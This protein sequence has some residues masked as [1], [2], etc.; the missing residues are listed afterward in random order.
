M[1]GKFKDFV[2]SGRN[3]PVRMNA[4]AGGRFLTLEDC[5]F[6][7]VRVEYT[8][9]G[10]SGLT[11]YEYQSDMLFA[12]LHR[13]NPEAL[14]IKNVLLH[15]RYL[16]QWIHA[17]ASK[18][19][20]YEDRVDAL[21]RISHKFDAFNRAAVVDVGF[22]ELGLS[23]GQVEYG[24]QFL[25]AV[26]RRSFYFDLR[27]VESWPFGRV[28]N[29]CWMLQDLVTLGCDYPSAVTGVTFEHAQQSGDAAD[30]ERQPI[31]PYIRAIGH[32]TSGS[33]DSM[34]IGNAMFTFHD[35]GGMEGEIKWLEVAS[36]Y[37]IVVGALVGNLYSASPYP[38]S[39]FFNACTAAEAFRRIQLGKQSLHLAK[40]LSVLAKQDGDAFKDLVGDV[41]KWA[42]RVVT[43]RV[44]S[45][46][47]PGLHGG[48]DVHALDWLA[49]SLHL[50]VV[51]CLLAECGVQKKA[52][53]R[54]RLSYRFLSVEAG[55]VSVW[56]TSYVRVKWEAT[57]R[58]LRV[59]GH[60]DERGN[61]MG[62]GY[63][64]CKGEAA[65]TVV[66]GLL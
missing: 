28:M 62:T 61:R 30:E 63:R 41:D 14:Q 31:R 33:F 24:D 60:S 40:E 56:V 27:L 58:R 26:R 39:R 10:Q 2:P 66:E 1:I 8:G 59:R 23:Y 19:I 50:L 34:G 17:L 32:Y 5:H 16:E 25:E 49:D 35:I 11:R 48:A 46:V 18:P 6:E 9:G 4:I 29:W 52:E 43:S 7:R 15:L 45:V 44:K 37:R 55:L 47:H 51:L 22:G 13:D 42:K 20:G 36:R 57:I 12:G 21:P 38:E 3:P 65:A 64:P 54:I 53:E